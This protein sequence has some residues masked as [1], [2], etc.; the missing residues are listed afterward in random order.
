MGLSLIVVRQKI[1]QKPSASAQRSRQ[2]NS[3]RQ[4][5]RHTDPQREGSSFGPDEGQG[6]WTEM[7]AQT[8]CLS[9]SFYVLLANTADL[10]THSG[11][12]V[13]LWAQ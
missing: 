12:L 6:L 10:T 13:C 5:D 9:S 11:H 3:D 7:A 4:T 1:I 8:P 2:T